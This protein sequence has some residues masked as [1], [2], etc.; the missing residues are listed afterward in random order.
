M[1]IPMLRF[2]AVTRH[3]GGLVALNA[4]SFE[5]GTGEIVGLIGPNGSGK[6]TLANIAT[7]LL[8][9]T[10]GAVYMEESR[11]SGSASWRVARAGVAR[12]FQMLRL[13]PTLSVADNIALAMQ[14]G[15]KTGYGASIFRTG[16]ASRE[17]AQVRAKTIEMLSL[18]DLEKHIDQPATALSIGQ[19]RMV[20]LARG[21]A[22]APRVFVLDEPAAGLSPPMVD[23]LIEVIRRMREDYGVTV[24]LVEH[25]MRLVQAVCDRVVVLDYGEK[26]ADAAPSI[27]VKDPRVVEAYLGVGRAEHA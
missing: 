10:S 2:D 22:T 19:Q 26:I 27:A 13:F 3:F 5:V 8:A 9:P 4:V 1:S 18:F 23:R 24:L 25:V 20:E 12:T 11:L 6:S 21:L 15:L 7:G 16:A 17:D 14:S